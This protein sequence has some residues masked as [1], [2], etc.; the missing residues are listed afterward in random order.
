MTNNF[1]LQGERAHREMIETRRRTIE[2]HKD[3]EDFV[4]VQDEYSCG[5]GCLVIKKLIDDAATAQDIFG[6]DELEEYADE[7]RRKAKAAMR[8]VPVEGEY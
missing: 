7:K 8:K 5:P 6:D 2:A 1:L 3:C 4:V